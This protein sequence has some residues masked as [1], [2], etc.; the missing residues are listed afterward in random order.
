MR[1]HPADGTVV[2]RNSPTSAGKLGIDHLSHPSTLTEQALAGV[3][4]F[5]VQQGDRS[6]MEESFKVIID[7]LGHW[8]IDMVPGVEEIRIWSNELDHT[9][10]MTIC[11][12]DDSWA[13]REKA[14]AAMLEV[15]D[16]FIDDLS[17]V[18][19]FGPAEDCVRDSSSERSAVFASR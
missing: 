5:S 1:R 6:L 3:R 9:A 18:Y 15:R 8:S 4:A 11:L 2:R 7:T 17:L 19:S 10:D 13:A 12:R 16:N 14:I